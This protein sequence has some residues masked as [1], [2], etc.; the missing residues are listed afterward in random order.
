[1]NSL[2]QNP[3]RHLNPI[4][5]LNEAELALL[6]GGETANWRLHL[7]GSVCG[8]CR[9]KVAEYR[10][11]RESLAGR[12]ADF[13]LPKGYDWTELEAEMLGNIRLGVE[14]ASITPAPLRRTPTEWMDW[15]GLVAIGALTAVV[16]TGWFLAGPAR[17]NSPRFPG[18]SQVAVAEGDLKLSGNPM[19]M[20]WE[21]GDH[22]V[23][24]RSTTPTA[25][26]VA[27]GLDGSLRS[28][29]VDQ[30]SGQLTVTQVSLGDG[31]YGSDEE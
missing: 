5:H 17:Q 20:G 8:H 29:T 21:S 9:A 10:E 26:R 14:V 24:F 19:Q 18:L 16:M 11:L 12:S 28:S 25:T 3:V 30:E 27:I 15:R 31:V 6:A 22:G 4:R 1:M 7:H 2:L 13:R 23:Y